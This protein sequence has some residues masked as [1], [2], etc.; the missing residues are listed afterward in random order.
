M[1]A[2]IAKVTRWQAPNSWRGEDVVN[3]KM[4]GVC[5]DVE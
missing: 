2:M 1:V 5:A 3:S 4:R